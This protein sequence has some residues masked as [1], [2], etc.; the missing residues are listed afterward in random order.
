MM[1]KDKWGFNKWAKSYDKD[2]AASARDGNW[3]YQDYNRI[4]D[5][6]VEYCELFGYKHPTILD[7]GIGTGELAS[8]FLK[9]GLS[10][11]GI[12]PSNEMRKICQQKFPEIKVD[13]GSFLDILLPAESID[14][15]V[16]S[17]AFHH[18]TAAEK[19]KAIIEMKRVLKPHG[20]IVVADLMFK[21]MSSETR[22]KQS[23]RESGKSNII[24]EIEDEYY[25]LFDDLKKSFRK[26][27]FNFKGEQLTD[28]VWIFRACLDS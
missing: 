12:D 20:R 16:S 14:I 23:I 3:M 1:L 2:V 13:A 5:K 6:V 26:E 9:N 25:G 10:V 7:I 17:Y 4:L 8:R 22:I 11:Q 24:E 27:G 18:L 15:I 21:N 19:D 28:F